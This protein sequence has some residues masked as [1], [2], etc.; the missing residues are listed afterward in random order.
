MPAGN[1]YPSGPS[2]RPFVEIAYAPIVETSF[3]AFAVS[4]LDFSP[5][6]S[7]GTF[8]SL[9]YCLQVFITHPND[10]LESSFKMFIYYASFL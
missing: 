1:A 2:F 5:W 4:F 6:I 8:S 10:K 7:L 9:L 3:P